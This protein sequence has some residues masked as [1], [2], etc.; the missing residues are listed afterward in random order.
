MTSYDEHGRELV[1][2]DDMTV[3]LTRGESPESL[4]HYLASN[5][6]AEATRRERLLVLVERFGLSFTD[7]RLCFDRFGGGIVRAQSGNPLNVPDPAKD[8]VAYASCQLELGLLPEPE[9]ESPYS[10]SERA[11]ADDLLDRARRGEPRRGSRNVGTALA[12]TESAVAST[13]ADSVRFHLLTEAATC[14]SVATEA[15]VDELGSQPSA[16]EA[17]Q[18]W[19]DATSL[20]AAAR[21]ITG[22]FAA[23]PDPELEEQALSLVA[24]IV[25]R[26]LC[27]SHALVG[28]AMIDSAERALRNGNPSIAADRAG[29]V[30]SDFS[31]YLLD[32]FA[33]EDPYDEY[34]IA[35]E[36]LLRALDL[37][38]EIQGPDPELAADRAR[39][40]ETLGR[41]E[42]E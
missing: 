32:R 29:A 15:I 30:V 8:L 40:T 34:V 26:L 31:G 6:A 38:I 27:S 39:V 25:T 23:Q 3:M 37:V 10:S 14:V 18:E 2:T 41:G 4:V 16:F 20:A 21:S 1:W 42:L 9:R 35:L 13:E 24:R 33:D 5:D 36:Y 12:A 19:V 28:R 22:A 11:E 17:S 7:A